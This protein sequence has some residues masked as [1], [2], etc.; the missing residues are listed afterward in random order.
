MA[1]FPDYKD[2][3]VFVE[4]KD[5]EPAD[6]GYELISE[7]RKLVAS[8]PERDFKVVGV[9]LGENVKEKAQDV[10][11]HGADKVIVVDDPLL[12]DYSTQFYTDAVTQV[13]E[14]FKPDAMLTG[15]TVLGR[16]LAPRVAARINA[17]LTAD[18]TGIEMLSGVEKV[19]QAAVQPDD[20]TMLVTR[21][22]FGGNLFGTIICPTTRPQM[23]TIRPKVFDMDP[24]DE[25]RTGE[26]VEFKPVWK[27]T[28]PEVEV[29][30][31]I[32]KVQEGVDITKCDIL[33]GAGRGAE[34]CLDTLR[35]AAEEL[36]GEVCGT[37]AVVEDGYLDKA[38]QV[39][40]TG[41][42]VRPSLYIACGISGACQH[43]AGMEK[44]DMIIAIN[45]DPSA[46]IFTIA[47]MGFVG[48]VNQILP[49]LVEEIKKAKAA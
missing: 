28:E 49:L 41:K 11:A 7:G 36:G 8:V 19:G 33:I 16:D 17:G 40:Q 44:S 1:T 31:V 35:A 9:L 45:R 47:N 29:Q 23:A 5:G 3:F 22:T 37:R 26:V 20:V 34:G 4:Q 43:V 25:T 42:T 32:E 27:S 10:I 12:K 48:D 18:A 24:V 2:L 38:V 39:G 14:E 15:A 6:V 13:I 46:E 21:P 30:K